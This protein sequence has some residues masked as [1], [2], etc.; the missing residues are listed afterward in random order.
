MTILFRTDASIAMGS[1]HVMRCL[2]L[3]DEL[4][5]RGAEV[6]FMCREHTGHLISL[7]EGKGYQ[8]VRLQQPESEYVTAPE[9]VS[10]AAWLGVSWQQDAADTINALADAH[11]QWLIIDHYAIDYRWEQK[12][13]SHVGKIM[14]VDDLADRPHDCDLLLDQNLYQSMETRYDNQVP[15][16]CQKL[17]GPKFALLRPEFGAARKTLRQRSGEIKRVLVFF[18]GVDSTNE[19]EKALQALASVTDHQFDVDVVVG[20]GNLN[21]ERISN[22]CSLYERFH[23]YCQVDNMAELMTSADFAIGAGGSTT[24]ER[25]SLGLPS[26]VITLAENQV[27][28]AQSAAKAGVLKYIGYF[29]TVSVEKLCQTISTAFAT[30]GILNNM[31][32]NAQTLV[33]GEGVMRV[34]DIMEQL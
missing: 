25:C 2:T 19:T 20:G 1:G 8:V 32:E 22:I 17:L 15:N 4:R 28:I 6:M 3:A 16:T 13:R 33:D 21:K 34:A 24:W 27:H 5:K 29:N 30:E 18:G 9:D 7:I 14:V 26:L 11:P 31:S 23:Y 10:H 12:L